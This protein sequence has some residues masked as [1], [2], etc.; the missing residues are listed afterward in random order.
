VIIAGDVTVICASVM[1]IAA[2]SCTGKLLVGKATAFVEGISWDT[3]SMLN[4]PVLQ[5]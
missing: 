4:M 2:N 1:N 3:M 5:K